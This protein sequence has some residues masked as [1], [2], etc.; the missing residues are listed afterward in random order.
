MSA[1]IT[2]V[3]KKEYPKE[4]KKL[5]S[6]YTIQKL[7]KW[8]FIISGLLILVAIILYFFLEENNFELALIPGIFALG[9]LYFVFFHIKKPYE[10]LSELSSIAVPL[11]IHHHGWNIEYEFRKKPHLKEFRSSRLYPYNLSNI[12]GSHF[13]SGIAKKLPFIA[14]FI[15][16]SYIDKVGESALS[17]V[18]SSSEFSGFLGFQIIVKNLVPHLNGIVVVQKEKSEDIVSLYRFYA[19]EKTWKEMTSDDSGF[20]KKY[21]VFTPDKNPENVVPQLVMSKVSKLESK[22]SKPFSLSIR[23][24]HVFLNQY[25]ETDFASLKL[26]QKLDQNIITLE[27]NIEELI[28]LSFVLALPS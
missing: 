26:D 19:S 11:I 21:A 20:K 14:S 28:G 24:N 23:R 10:A 15:E 7:R 2:S 27:Q 16:A 5:K 1:S 4:W 25:W 9:G 12:N 13:F 18:S 22:S 8:L 6:I 3:F 17:M